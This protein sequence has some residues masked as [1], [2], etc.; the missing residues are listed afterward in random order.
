MKAINTPMRMRRNDKVDGDSGRERL[1]LCGCCEH[2]SQFCCFIVEY[3]LVQCLRS[4]CFGG[5]VVISVAE[6]INFFFFFW[7]KFD[8][9]VENSVFS[10]EI[11]Y[12]RWKFN[13]LRQQFDFAGVN[14]I[15]S[16]EIRFCRCELGVFYEIS[17]VSGGNFFFL[18]KLNIDG[19]NSVFSDENPI[20]PV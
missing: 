4:L 6:T 1:V 13:F 18:R 19:V 15:F 8:F 2:L 16:T 10:T 14:S 5:V 17:F 20:F 7:R 12:C 11:R 3:R 9:F